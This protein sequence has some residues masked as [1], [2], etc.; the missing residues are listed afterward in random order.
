[1]YTRTVRGGIEELFNAHLH[2][3][4]CSIS[5]FLLLLQGIRCFS[6]LYDN[7]EVH[8]VPTARRP[9]IRVSVCGLFP[10]VAFRLNPALP[11]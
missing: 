11:S 4:V 7:S 10:S 3:R 6:L 5:I 8:S 9:L 1:M 2:T